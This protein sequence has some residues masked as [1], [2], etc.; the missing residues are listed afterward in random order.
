[1]TSKEPSNPHGQERAFRG[2]LSVRLSVGHATSC[3]PGSFGVAAL[4][5]R[6]VVFRHTCLWPEGGARAN[7]CVE[8]RRGAELSSLS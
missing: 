4:P 2:C 7:R 5:K 6:Q 8:R 1:M 3:G